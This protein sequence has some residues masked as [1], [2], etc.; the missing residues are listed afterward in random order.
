MQTKHAEHRI[1]PRTLV[2]RLNQLPE[3]YRGITLSGG[4]PLDQ[5]RALDAFFEEVHVFFPHWDIILFSG[6]TWKNLRKDSSRRKMV[7]RH[8][9]LLIDGPYQQAIPSRH[10]LAGSG[11]QR[12]IALSRKGE[13]LLHDCDLMVNTAWNLG[14]PSQSRLGF[15]MPAFLIGILS[16]E[17]RRQV[18]Q[19]LGVRSGEPHHRKQVT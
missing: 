6:Y 8:V 2:T 15:S 1:S 14:V 9:D 10:P 19:M 5:S 12:L 13:S 17:Q 7:T 18:H 16:P 3:T 11:N 4:E